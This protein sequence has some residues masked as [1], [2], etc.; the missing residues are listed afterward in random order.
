MSPLK[1]FGNFYNKKEPWILGQY[2]FLIN[3]NANDT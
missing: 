1:K 3:S 2:K